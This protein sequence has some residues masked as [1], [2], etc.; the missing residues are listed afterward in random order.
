MFLKIYDRKYMNRSLN[1]SGK[2]IQ[3]IVLFRIF[4]KQ[5]FSQN[6]ILFNKYCTEIC[7]FK[8]SNDNIILNY[9]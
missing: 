3:S 4:F 7:S 6:F 2:N 1:S 8:N 5:L 9:I